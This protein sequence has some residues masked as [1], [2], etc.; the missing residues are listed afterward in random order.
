MEPILTAVDEILFFWDVTLCSLAQRYG[1]L[2]TDSTASRLRRL[3]LNIHRRK[4]IET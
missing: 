1:Q 3:Y 4:N 2:F